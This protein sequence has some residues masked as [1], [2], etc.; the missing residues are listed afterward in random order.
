LLSVIIVN[1]NVKHFLEQCLFSVLHAI[2]DMDAEVIVVDNASTDG[3]KD[4]LQNLDLQNL[5]LGGRGFG[6]SP[7]CR[8]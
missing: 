1:Y 7:Y 3:S 2:K 6:G 8:L 4:Y 5:D